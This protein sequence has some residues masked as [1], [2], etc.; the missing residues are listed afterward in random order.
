MQREYEATGISRP[1][2][3]MSVAMLKGKVLALMEG[4]LN[5]GNGLRST[6]R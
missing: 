1:T 3:E 5:C 2:E 6:N 4:N